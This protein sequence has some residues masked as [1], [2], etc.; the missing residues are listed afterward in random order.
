MSVE[1]PP[2]RC[3]RRP[4]DDTKLVGYDEYIDTQIRSTRRAVKLVDL[5]TAL[6]LL[7]AGMLAFLLTAAV[8]ENWVM[9]GG[10]SFIERVALFTVLAAGVVFFA[11]RWLW[12]LLARAINPVYAAQAIE[13]SSPTLK[14]SL[15]NLLLFRQRRSDISDAVYHT[16]E[17]QAAQRLTRVPLDSAVDRTL[18]IRCGYVLIGIVALAGLYK[19]FS[20]KDPLVAARRVL[21]PWARIVPASRVTITAIE[22]GTTTVSRGEFLDVSAEVRGLG[23]DETVALRF[24][25]SDGQFVDKVVPLKINRDTSRFTCRVPDEAPTTGGAGLTRNLIYHLEAGDA[26][27]LD[28]KV[29]VVAAPSILVERV[30]YDYPEYT[31]YVDHEVAGLGDLR[32]IEGTNVTIHAR[33]NDPIREVDVDFDADGVRDVN[34]AASDSEAQATFALALR[35]DRQTPEHASYVLRFANKDG[36][37][38]RDPVKH[39]ITVDPDLSPEAAIVAPQEKIFDVR[40]DQPVTIE[41][42][43]NDPDFGLAGVRLKGQLAGRDL[44]DKPLLS[45]KHRGGHRSQYKFF[46]SD[47]KL[48]AGDVVQYWVEATDVRAPVANVTKSE[49][50]AL[51]IVSPDPAR[52]P[53]PD[54]LAQN[55][56]QQPRDQQRG[57]QQQGQ[58]DKETGRQGDKESHGGNAQDNQAVGRD[59]QQSED[60]GQ[61]NKETGGQGEGEEKQEGETGRQGDKESSGAGQGSERN[62]NAEG[63]DPQSTQQG[64]GKDQSGGQAGK[65]QQSSRGEQNGKQSQQGDNQNKQTGAGTAGGESSKDG[66]Q[67]AG[68]RPDEGEREGEKG[69]GGKGEK[70][71][72]QS[73]LGDQKSPVSSE[74]DNDGDAF[75]RIRRHM[76]QKGELKDG[77]SESD[78]GGD[79]GGDAQRS[80]ERSDKETRRQGDKEKSEGAPQKDG[81]SE[82]LKGD[83]DKETGRRGDKDARGADAQKEKGESKDGEQKEMGT[84]SGVGEESREEK[85][86][87]GDETGTK[88]ESG[89]GEE[90]KPDGAPNSQ[91]QLKPSEK[92]EQAASNKDQ[93]DKTEPS[94]AAHGKKESDS[95]GEQGG[96]KSGGGEEGGG[97]KSPRDGT[98]SAGENQS[99]DKGAGESSEKGAGN[100]S[101]T[102]GRDAQS[103]RPTGES[104]GVTQ[105][106]GSKTRQ[107]D[108]ETGRQGEGEEKP[109]AEK[110]R[111]RDEENREAVSRDAERS[112]AQGQGDKEKGRQ[113]DKENQDAKPPGERRGSQTG[114]GGGKVPDE[115]IQPGQSGGTAPD[116]DAANL[117]YARKQTDMVLEKLS[118]QLNR[119]KVDENLLK[120][121]GWSEADLQKF[122]QRWQARKDAAARN[123][124]A[125]EAARRELD[126][127]LRSLGL[128][129]GPLQQS[130]VRDDTM[131]DLREGYRGPVPPAYQERLRAYNQGVSRAKREAE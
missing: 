105:G 3:E 17:E 13:Q 119:K 28:Y 7:A 99:A 14:N 57:D 78:E 102:A 9:P 89:A 84:E 117:E 111:G 77:E 103:N 25:T 96:G 104:D 38:N 113:E 107:G 116:G 65:D 62:P 48:K 72:P 44:L 35:E 122:I 69:S 80:A 21:M 71:K 68:T 75:E 30:Q 58:A 2:V 128:R 6:I 131:R 123:D 63:A 32:A 127:A 82:S 120:D 112:A 115:A 109:E 129:R 50:K 4:K 108:K 93:T 124:A 121:L 118:D 74:G 20:P 29:T 24:T 91:S 64:A 100:N 59:A 73:E 53:P 86:P 36:R 83:K 37:T 61:G 88:G 27:S 130:K 55:D 39:S 54:R 41:V 70:T 81:Q 125:G 23:E 26:R 101:Q 60:Q 31:G 19:I 92:R 18:L 1:Q 97:Q 79:V 87:Q 95:Q 98:G 49:T 34:M 5:A 66:A 67:S 42:E 10:Y 114:E 22:P 15:I 94:A 12:P 46:A 56:R 85:A 33:A 47:H 90:Q 8:V 52:Q 43:S 11:F 76:Q 16:L 126:D 110:G 40:L 45:A 51:R 106:R